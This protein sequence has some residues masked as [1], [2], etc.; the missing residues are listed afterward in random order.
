MPVSPQD[1]Y[2]LFDYAPLSTS[3]YNASI[4]LFTANSGNALALATFMP[5]GGAPQRTLLGAGL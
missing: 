3:T 2:G 1:S 4:S 5:G